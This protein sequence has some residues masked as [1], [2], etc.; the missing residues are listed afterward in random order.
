ML[1]MQPQQDAARLDVAALK[2]APTTCVH[3]L[4]SRLI[5][6]KRNATGKRPPPSCCSSANRSGTRQDRRHDRTRAAPDSWQ[7]YYGDVFVGHIGRRAG[8]PTKWGWR[9]DL[10]AR[11]QGC[12]GSNPTTSAITY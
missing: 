2:H 4:A 5:C 12:H 7:I 9:C 6:Q 11:L 1:Q 8:L 3:D 10:P